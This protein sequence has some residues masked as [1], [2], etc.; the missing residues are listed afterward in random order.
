MRTSGTGR[1]SLMIVIPV[2]IVLGLAVF[3]SGDPVAL[4]KTIDD[5]LAQAFVG[6]WNWV[7]HLIA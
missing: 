2:G 7:R 6:A 5:Y 4:L 1:D 3:V